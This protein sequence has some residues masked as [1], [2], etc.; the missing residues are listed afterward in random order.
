VE[1]ADLAGEPGPILGD[2]SLRSWC[3]LAA[4]AGPVALLSQAARRGG[5][6]R[7]APELEEGDRP[8]AVGVAKI[9]TL[10]GTPV[11]AALTDLPIARRQVARPE[12]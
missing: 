3:P 5:V 11:E 1:V 9:D 10:T 6:P 2:P 12:R 8:Q 4:T 7:R